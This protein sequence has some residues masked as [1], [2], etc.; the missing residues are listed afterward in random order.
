MEI[1][2]DEKGGG[3]PVLVE[4]NLRDEEL[5][6]SQHDFVGW[7]LQLLEQPHVL[8]CAVKKRVIQ[9]LLNLHSALPVVLPQEVIDSAVRL[10]VQ[11]FLVN[12][13]HIAAAAKLVGRSFW[14]D[15]HH[16]LALLAHFVQHSYYIY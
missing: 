12:G 13:A 2:I 3:L 15:I 9:P 6:A 10:I 14:R 1:A 11:L 7:K 8:L 16:T 5:D 4:A